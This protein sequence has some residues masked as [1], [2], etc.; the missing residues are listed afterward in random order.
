MT[1]DLGELRELNMQIAEVEH[2]D[3]DLQRSWFK[4]VLASAFAFRRASKDVEDRGKFLDSVSEKAARTTEIES[5]ELVGEARAV[6]RA[7]V[8]V[9]G[10]V[11]QRFHNLRLFIRTDDGWKLLGWANEGPLPDVVREPAANAAR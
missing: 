9:Q 11:P 8:T 6:V 3:V 5:I 7:I 1:N 10:D 2:K 4:K